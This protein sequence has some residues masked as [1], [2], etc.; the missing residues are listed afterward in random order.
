MNGRTLP[1]WDALTHVKRI[2]W[3]A[4]AQAVAMAVLPSSLDLTSHDDEELE[5][6]ILSE[7]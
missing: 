1:S 7:N 4:A 6:D 3:E 5:T 2:G